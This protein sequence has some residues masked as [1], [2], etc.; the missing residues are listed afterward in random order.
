MVLQR[1]IGISK[2]KTKD[3]QTELDIF[4]YILAS[5][6]IFRHNQAYSGIIQAYS[7]SCVTLAYLAPLYIRKPWY[8]QNSGIFRILK[9]SESEA[10]SEPCQ[11]STMKR[12]AKIFNAIIILAKYI[13]FRNTS[14]SRSLLYEINIMNFSNY[15][16]N[17]YSRSIHSM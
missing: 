9:Y 13:Y 6:N 2:C 8:I 10:Y 1:R 12:F 16:S 15:R 4:T 3:I 17:F 7:E 5:S 14:F 11:T